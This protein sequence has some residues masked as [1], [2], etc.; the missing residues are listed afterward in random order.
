MS[1]YTYKV[2][3]QAISP[4]SHSYV[5]TDEGS[6]RQIDLPQGGNGI[7]L[8]RCPEIEADLL[9]QHD[10]SVTLIYRARGA[11]DD[12]DLDYANDV[13]TWTFHR[14]ANTIIVKDLPRPVMR[15]TMAHPSP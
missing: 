13:F 12:L 2:S 1:T 8:G 11:Q 9:K 5:A 3:M 10:L 4:G 7:Y 15:V 14:G 6:G